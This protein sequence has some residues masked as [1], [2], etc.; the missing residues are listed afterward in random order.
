MPTQ[1]FDERW[2][3]AL[4]EAKALNTALTSANSGAL[5][6]PLA[7]A[8]LGVQQLPA[9]G[10]PRAAALSRPPSETVARGR[11][12]GAATRLLLCTPS[13]EVERLQRERD[14]ACA[15]LD[16]AQAALD[17]ARATT[18]A[19]R[20]ATRAF[21]V[22][23]RNENAGLVQQQE[24][25]QREAAVRLEQEQR[26]ATERLE[27]Q[28]REAAERLEREQREAAERLEREQREA[29]ERLSA[30][31]EE[32]AAA[33]EREGLLQAELQVLAG[34]PALDSLRQRA[35][36]RAGQSVSGG[37]LPL[38]RLPHQPPQ[39]VQARVEAQ[40]HIIEEMGATEEVRSAG[41]ATGAGVAERESLS[42][43]AWRG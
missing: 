17:D 35:L 31:E 3:S 41:G 6:P 29:A 33:L 18:G 27:R 14:E 26:E 12:T 42:N 30:K 4:E 1:D 7:T 15:A 5:G 37:D 34:R 13:P 19:Q 20:V 2:E 16:A 24:R 10:R 32:L 38:S 21:V 9:R 8:V 25:Q 43:K 11:L 36:R 40:G 22:A 39:A 28:Q 23:L